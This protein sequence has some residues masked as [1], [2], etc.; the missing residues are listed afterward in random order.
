ME[1]WQTTL[2]VALLS[3][4]G[5]VAAALIAARY[6]FLG[7]LYERIANVEREE[8]LC[9]AEVFELRSEMQTIYFINDVLA[10]KCPEVDDEV[11]EIRERIAR[12][13]AKFAE[14]FGEAVK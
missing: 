6:T 5:G 4:G 9:R 10:Q 3:A 14:R 7:K 2:I 12:R 13:R 1:P 8:R 11:H